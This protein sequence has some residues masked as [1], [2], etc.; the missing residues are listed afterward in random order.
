VAATATA[1]VWLVG[2]RRLSLRRALV[3]LLPLGAV[4]AHVAW[5]RAFYGD[6]L[7]NTYYAKVVAPWPE[8]GWRYLGCFTF[9]HGTWLVAIVALVWLLREIVVSWRA[10]WHWLRDRPAA[11]AAVASC[12]LHAAYYVLR[13]GGDHFEYR[14]FSQFVPLLVLATAAMA[15][16]IARSPKVAVIALLAL[17]LASGFGWLQLFLT[18]G[19]HRQPFQAIAQAVP[20]PLRPLARW[21]DRQQAW[22][23]FQ[24]VGLRC[25]YHH[26]MLHREFLP[27]LPTRVHFGAEAGP[28]PIFVAQGVGIVGWSLPDCCIIDH[29]GLN[30]WVIARVPMPIGDPGLA[31]KVLEPLIAAANRNGDD[32]FDRDEIRAAM[33]ALAPN[34]N[35]DQ[36]VRDTAENLIEILLAIYADE[37]F[38]A[39][40]MA[41]AARISDLLATVRS[42]AHER[43]PPAGYVEA[44]APN[45]QLAAGRPIVM[46]R[47]Q[48]MTAERIRSSE[49]EWRRKL[50]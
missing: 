42:M 35:P 5:R 45:V 43:H 15:L 10:P 4:L 37:R 25:A 39:M 16:R 12:L 38:D 27:A 11:I 28:F 14:V 19:P 49:Q 26:S 31:G 22:L 41:S 21:F 50:R 48:P 23:Q 33:A 46:P 2:R 9:E 6:W 44:F 3:G 13:V 32:W 34:A 8:A 47:A 24:N 20:S 29:H 17:G 36:R 30:D 1:A 18:A 40:T 7:P